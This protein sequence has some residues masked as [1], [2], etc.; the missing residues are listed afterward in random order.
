MKAACAQFANEIGRPD[1]AKAVLGNDRPDAEPNAQNSD[2]KAAF[3][4]AVGLEGRRADALG[5]LDQILA[6]DP[7]QPRALLARARLLGTTASNW[8]AAVSDVRRV[9]ADDPR[10]VTARLMLAELLLGRKDQELGESILREGARITPDEPRIAA[11]L[12]KLLIDRGQKDEAAQVLRD[13][14]LA[15]PASLRA[16]RLRASIDPTATDPTRVPPSP[17]DT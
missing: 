13:L 16:Q 10:N 9:V 14:T 4:L 17:R 1:I 8:N 5:R 7:S 2:A 15:A 6:V 11:R 3:A 12:A